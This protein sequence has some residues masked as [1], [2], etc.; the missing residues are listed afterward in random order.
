MLQEF[1]SSGTLNLVYAGVVLTSFVFAV[2]T[3][4]GSEIGD[5]LDF[6]IDID[7]DVDGDIGFVSLSPFSMAMFGASFG[8]TGLIT[9]IW[10]NMDSIPSVLWAVGIGLLFGA[11]AQPLFIY[12]LSP[13]KSSHFSLAEDAPGREA[14]VIISVPSSGLGKIAFDNVSG[15]VTLGAR[16]ATGSEIR[17][18]QIVQIERINGRVAL[19]RPLNSNQ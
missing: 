16:S 2:L 13:T 6:D 15:R 11:G 9:R 7:A 19:V 4:F 18:G 14:E 5:A 17:T 3:L 8:L 12:V 1:L 10:L